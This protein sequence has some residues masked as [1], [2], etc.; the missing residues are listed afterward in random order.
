[1]RVASASRCD[2]S[3][4]STPYKLAPHNFVA[5]QAKAHSR[6]IY[7]PPVN[8]ALLDGMQAIFDGASSGAAL[9]A[10]MAAAA[11]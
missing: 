4:Y 5:A 2:G 8:A 1:M 7:T 3:G 9:S 6:T 10:A 11:K